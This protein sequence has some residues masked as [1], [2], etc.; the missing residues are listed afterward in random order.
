MMLV[1]PH[2]GKIDGLTVYRNVASLP[3]ALYLAVIFTPPET[4]PGLIGDLAERGTRAAV[5]VT[6]GFRQGR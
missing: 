6:A 4:V 2:H 5:I 3:Q 1:N